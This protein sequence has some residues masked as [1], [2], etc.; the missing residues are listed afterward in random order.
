MK[1]SLE[2][3]VSSLTATN[4]TV[5]ENGSILLQYIK[6]TDV[7]FQYSISILNDPLL[8][9]FIQ[10]IM[11]IFTSIKF[12]CNLDSTF[13][14][15]SDSVAIFLTKLLSISPYLRD[16]IIIYMQFDDIIDNIFTKVVEE[17]DIRKIEPVKTI[18][19]IKLVALLSSSIN[20]SLTCVKSI[21]TLFKI[22]VSLIDSPQLG[23]WACSIIALLTRSTKAV[24][25]YLKSQQSILQVKKEL[26]RLLSSQDMM[27][28]NAA[29]STYTAIFPIGNEAAMSI[30]AAVNFISQDTKFILMKQLARDTILSLK[31]KTQI[32]QKEIVVLLTSILNSTGIDSYFIIDCIRQLT[33]YHVQFAATIKST[34]F[35]VKFVDYI[36]NCEYDFV[37]VSACHLLQILCDNEPTLFEEMPGIDLFSNIFNKFLALP[38]NA[39]TERLESIFLVLFLIIKNNALAQEDIELLQEEE[40]FLFTNFVRQIELNNAYLSLII[41]RFLDECCTYIEKWKTKIN[42]IAIETQLPALIVN[43]LQNSR[44]KYAIEFAYYA[45]FEFISKSN[46]FFDTFVNITTH[47]NI[48]LLD[49]RNKLINKMNT[50]YS[51]N[52]Q[53]ISLLTQENEKLKREIEEIKKENTKLKLDSAS[54]NNELN[55]TKKNN[56]IQQ[57]KISDLSKRLDALQLE[58]KRLQKENDDLSEVVNNNGLATKRILHDNKDLYQQVQL[59]QNTERSKQKRIEELTEELKLK[60]EEFTKMTI[61]VQRKDSELSIAQNRASSA[62]NKLLSLEKKLIEQKE[63]NKKLCRAAEK[64]KEDMMAAEQRAN[65]LSDDVTK[66]EMQNKKLLE[67]QQNLLDKTEK[68]KKQ[69]NELQEMIKVTQKERIKWETIAKFAQKVKECK[70]EAAEEVFAPLSQCNCKK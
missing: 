2:S 18:I 43:I 54:S 1:S 15:L 44:N 48:N 19:Y 16:Q 28:V 29:L 26:T 17:G 35:I 25:S 53:T 39:Q 59:Y 57:E 5:N 51:R 11:M 38:D 20:T 9:D 6:T 49:E 7:D 34:D 45:L 14:E 70:R 56:N 8:S 50:E 63:V 69:I 40:S 68:Y 30:R 66:V 23:A 22:V 62:E 61:S 37:S 24:E 13:N 31:E 52:S 60:S 27:I 47:S 55:F 64:I 36:T 42:R 67:S 58:N 4:H 32:S 12:D 41:L 46:H 21:S 33:A 65:A 10:Q 3:I